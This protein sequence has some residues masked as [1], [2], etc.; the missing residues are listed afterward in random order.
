MIKCELG[1]VKIEGSASTLLAELTCINRALYECLL[2]DKSE[3]VA[4]ELILKT[5]EK[6]FM[7]LVELKS[8]TKAKIA[9]LLNLL[10]GD[11]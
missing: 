10:F 9:E 4:K 1:N 2:E 5:T 11:E 6:A 8:D 3:D 7:S